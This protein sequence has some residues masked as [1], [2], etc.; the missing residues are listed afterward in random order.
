MGLI[1]HSIDKT[2]ERREW[3]KELEEIN[4]ECGERLLNIEWRFR[5]VKA[6]ADGLIAE[7]YALN[8]TAKEEAEMMKAMFDKFD[9]V[10]AENKALKDTAK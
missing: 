6:S 5:D 8:Q 7:L 1:Y 9:K 2:V 3:I 4:Q 10:K